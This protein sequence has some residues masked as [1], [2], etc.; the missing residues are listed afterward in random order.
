[1]KMELKTGGIE[2]E[3]KVRGVRGLTTLAAMGMVAAAVVGE[4][5]KPPEQRTW[6]GKLLGL[7]PYDFRPP[8]TRRIKSEFWNEETDDLLTPHAFGVGWGVNLRAVAK[9]LDLAA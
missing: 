6:H 8:T 5:R 7:V 2:L 9:K 3:L 4:L 1:M